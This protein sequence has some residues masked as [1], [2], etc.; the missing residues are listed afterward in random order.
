MG[1]QLKLSSIAAVNVNQYNFGTAL[2]MPNKTKRT[3]V[4]TYILLI[5]NSSPE[6]ICKRN[7]SL[8]PLEDIYKRLC[9]FIHNS[10]KTANNSNTDQQSNE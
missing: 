8:C 3:H 6:Y 10:P 2:A 5:S 7:E 1:R 4:Y 9:S